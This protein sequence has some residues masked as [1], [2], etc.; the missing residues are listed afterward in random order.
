VKIILASSERFSGCVIDAL[1]KNGHEVVGVISPARGIYERQL[2][3]PRVFLHRLRGWDVLESCEKRGINFRVA[4]HLDEGATT[5]FF[6][7]Q[8]ADLLLLFGWPTMVKQ[9]TMALFT[10]GSMNIHPSLLPKLRGADPLFDIVDTGQASFGVTFH[11]VVDE[12]DAGNIVLQEPIPFAPG[13][14]YDD[15][16]FRLL[17]HIHRHTAQALAQLKALP[18]GTPQKGEP[19]VVRKFNNHMRVLDFH[20]T[21]DRIRRRTHACFS[22]HTRLASV[23]ERL[24][25][26][27]KCKLVEG[28]APNFPQP[29]AIQSN[30]PFSLVILAGARCLRISGICFHG[31]PK[32]MTPLLLSKYC[33][34]GTQMDEAKTTLAIMGNHKDL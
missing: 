8:K 16:Y 14:T 11:K 7:A 12:L 9:E 30:G 18:E 29:G 2:Q 27:S 17:A 20:E 32:W 3:G 15:L 13:D 33:K 28:V 26:F 6:K 21:H 24:F 1:M 19:T 25:H 5:A 31:R 34:P 10:H 22:H 23:G 4:R